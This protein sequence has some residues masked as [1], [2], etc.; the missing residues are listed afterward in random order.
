MSVFASD[1]RV[2]SDGASFSIQ[3]WRGSGPPQVHVHEADDEAW[4]VLEGTLRFR[5]AE[6]TVEAA[7]G[8]TV[9]V[10]AG[11]AHT[12]EAL[13]GSRYLV[14]LTPRLRR[15]IAELQ[16]NRDPAAQAGIYQKHHSRLLA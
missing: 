11:T 13:P 2:D 5:L 3:E 7:A 1:Q 12:Y 15:L 6:R 8:T 16:Q 9:F 4:H 14:V 10:P